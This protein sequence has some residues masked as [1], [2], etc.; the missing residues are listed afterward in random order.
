MDSLYIWPES[1][2]ASVFV[3]WIASVVFLWA[4]RS[5]MLKLLQGLGGGL[6]EGFS[7][8]AQHCMTTAEDLRI[9]SRAVLLAAGTRDAQGRL[10]RELQRV[11]AGFSEQLGQYGQLQRRLDDTLLALENDYQQGGVAPPEV[12][13]WSAAVEAIANI[14]MAGDPNIQK[15]LE[16]IRKSSEDAEKKALSAY[17]GDTAKRHKILAAML[18]VWKGI[19]SLLGKMQDSVALA[20]ESSNR[21]NAFIEDYE[22]VRQDQEEAARALTFSAVKLFV[23]SALVLAIALGAAF[24]NFQL[25]ALPMSELVPAGARVG[26]MPVSTVS[27]L[28]LVLME[29]A[30]GIFVMDMLGITE[31]FPKLG[32]IPRSRKRLILG[33]AITALFFLASVES[34]L[35]VLREQIVEAE[36]ALKLSLAASESRI[37]QSASQSSI[38]VV[39]Q[40]VLGFILPWVLALVAVPLEMLLDSGRH[41]MASL[42]VLL[43]RALGAV[44]GAM[45]IVSRHL[46]GLVTSAYDVYVAIPLRIEA[47]VQGGRSSGPGRGERRDTPT[48]PQRTEGVA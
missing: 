25:I 22:K 20:L 12:P 15:V 36:A 4:A 43:L 3:L 31:L 5:A 46:T 14:P 32:T 38:P 41:V 26:G 10:D 33:L 19:R 27:A 40:A 7:S 1:P 13:G 29:A 35:A 9:R 37:V 44:S 18:P 6:A 30:L 48:G 24:V 11:D 2:L 8:I 16:G 45:A 42:G 47:L 23:V 39:G 21:I 34:S 17:R 28:V